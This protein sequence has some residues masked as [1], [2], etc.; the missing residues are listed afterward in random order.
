VGRNPS[1]EK[2]TTQVLEGWPDATHVSFSPEPP[3][4][5]KL[6]ALLA[7]ERVDIGWV[8]SGSAVR[9][10]AFLP[11]PFLVEAAAGFAAAFLGFG[12]EASDADVP[13]EVADLETTDVACDSLIGTTLEDT[14][15][16]GGRSSSPDG[17][18]W[19]KLH[20]VSRLATPGAVVR[21]SQPPRWGQTKYMYCYYY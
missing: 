5:R 9:V 19:M 7:R 8:A 11:A 12:D 13:D 2:I 16:A 18:G 1:W 4:P 6:P 20:A 15:T 14:R 17:P 21:W 3:T 10:D